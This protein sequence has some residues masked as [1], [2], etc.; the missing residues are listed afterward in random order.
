MFNN[1][2]IIMIIL[3]LLNLS[4][5]ENLGNLGDLTGGN[6]GS[7][8]KRFECKEVCNAIGHK[9]PAT[10]DLPIERTEGNR[11][12]QV[13]GIDFADPI[14][15]RTMKRERGKGVIRNNLFG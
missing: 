2:I 6:V 12:F 3:I 5:K 1:V 4:L 10:A 7:C 14:H 11:P 13:V 8:S 15:H 9:E